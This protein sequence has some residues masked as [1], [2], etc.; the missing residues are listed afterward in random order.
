MAKVSHPP[1]P[2]SYNG[3]AKPAY[4]LVGKPVVNEVGNIVTFQ[5]VLENTVTGKPATPDEMKSFMGHLLDLLSKE[6]H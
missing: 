3:S 2:Y 1:G 6:T 4:A 5:L